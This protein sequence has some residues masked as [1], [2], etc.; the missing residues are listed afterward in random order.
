MYYKPYFLLPSVF[1]N[2]N[3]SQLIIRKRAMDEFMTRRGLR[4]ETEEGVYHQN[5]V[6][7]GE[8]IINQTRNRHP[9]DPPMPFLT[10]S[11]HCIFDLPAKLDSQV[12]PSGAMRHIGV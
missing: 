3:K 9:D 11:L 6:A 12:V 10:H 8:F 7:M 5:K 4:R 2:K 1:L